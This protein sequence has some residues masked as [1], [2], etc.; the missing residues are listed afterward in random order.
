MELSGIVVREGFL[1]SSSN[2]NSKIKRDRKELARLR[3]GITFEIPN[4]YGDW[5]ANIL[6]PIDCTKYNWLIGPGEEYKVVENELVSLF[7]ANIHTVDG[8]TLLEFIKTESSQYIIYM[9]LKAFSTG[10]KVMNLE[11]FED[12]LHSDC[13][14]V[15][16]IV[17]C[18]HT[19]IYCKDPEI[20]DRLY[21]NAKELKLDSLT[22]ITSDN[23]FRTRLG[24]W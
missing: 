20:L 18:T 24:V 19:T 1:I 7:P 23:D 14:L 22:Y 6:K 3:R 17:D 10:K 2:I 12:F 21:L 5:L 9:D 8:Q 16:L 13:Q 11:T 15:L 4:E